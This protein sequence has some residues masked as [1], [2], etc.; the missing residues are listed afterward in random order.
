MFLLFQNIFL[1]KCQ[2]QFLACV[3]ALEGNNALCEQNRGTVSQS[4]FQSLIT[5]RKKIEKIKI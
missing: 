2:S 1:T 3:G 4:R 5:H